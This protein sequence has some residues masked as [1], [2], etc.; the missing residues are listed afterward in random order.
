MDST[1]I[2]VMVGLATIGAVSALVGCYAFLR[3]ST[4]VGDAVA[5]SVLPGVA[6]GFLLSGTK[7]P[8]YLLA[9]GIVFG[10]LAIRTISILQTRS[11]LSADTAIALVATVF[12]AAGS[13]L[14][15]YI[16]SLPNGHQAGLKDFLFGKAATMTEGDIFVFIYAA[17]LV[18]GAVLLYYR[19]FLLLSFNSD[20]AQSQGWNMKRYDWI[21]SI[22]TVLVIAL[23]LQAVGVVLMSALLIAPAASARYWTHS[24][25]KMM[26]LAAVFGASSGVTGGWLSL[27]GENMPTGPWVVMVLFGFTLFTLLF[28]PKRGYFSIRRRN[29]QN[30]DQMGEENLLKVLQQLT[31]VGVESASV[32]EIL[33]KRR[34]DTAELL[35]HLRKLEAKQWILTENNLYSLTDKGRTEAKR[36]VRLHRLWELYLTSRLNF[37]EDHI[38]GTAETIEHLI[39][40]DLE[41]ALLQ[42]LDYP[43]QDPHNKEIPYE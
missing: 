9:G 40:E 13:V 28:A 33:N 39:T 5:H 27:S 30:E 15:S 24:L 41:K 12:F 1:L 18:L 14:L 38:H 35:R 43:N 19:P 7:N 2:W 31:E 26:V 10:Y 6:I 11:K 8:I 17:F 20:F 25:K 34:T 23:G 21:L 16:S 4:L 37:K 42:E 22:L 3:K 32:T 36:I 29:K